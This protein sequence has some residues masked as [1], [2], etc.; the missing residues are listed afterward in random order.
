MNLENFEHIR[1][2]EDDDGNGFRLELYTAYQTRFGKDLLA[3]QFF[4]DDSL[5]FEGHDYCCSS[6]HSIDG[7]DSVAGLL[8]FLSLQPGDT[9]RDYFDDYS[10]RQLAFAKEHGETLSLYVEELER[11]MPD[12]WDVAETGV[13]D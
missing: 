8:A 9:D 2:W 1:T 12:G 10:E 6:L 13:E 11:G 4:H 3:Y 5:I 7:D